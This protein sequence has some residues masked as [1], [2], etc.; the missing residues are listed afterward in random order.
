MKSKKI[1]K[2]VSLLAAAACAVCVTA[3]LPR[4]TALAERAKT[5]VLA[6]DFNAQSLNASVWETTDEA[7]AGVRDYGGAL[8]M[9][10]SDYTHA[11]N[12]MGYHTTA[13]G[14]DGM[15]QDYSLELILTRECLPGN[16]AAIYL[17][18]ESADKGGNE[19]DEGSNGSRGYMLVIND[20]S[21]KL[22]TNST[23]KSTDDVIDP[24]LTADGTRYA[25]KIVTH[26]G[27]QGTDTLDLY[28]VKAPDDPEQPIDYGQMKGSIGVSGSISHIDLRGLFGFGALMGPNDKATFSKVK[29]TEGE[30]TWSPKDDFKTPDIDYIYGSQ[31]ADYSK[32]F[33]NWNSYKDQHVDM[34][35]N[36]PVGKLHVANGGEVVSKQE[37]TLD[38]SLIS[39]LDVSFKLK[40]ANAGDGCVV[41]LGKSGSA[42]LNAVF[43]QTD[44]GLALCL[45]ES[46]VA[47][48]NVTG[49]HSYRLLVRNTGSID[50][51]MDGELAGT[52]V[53][54]AVTD[55]KIGFKAAGSA[56]FEVD[57]LSVLTYSHRDSDEADISID[58][59]EKNSRGFTYLDPD[60]WY[61]AGNALVTRYDEISFVNAE[62]NSVFSS[63]KAYADYIFKFDLFDI[64]Q[65]ENGCS[66]IGISF[67]KPAYEGDWQTAPTIMFA[68]R[69]DGFGGV[70]MNIEGQSGADITG[71]NVKSD[72][73]VF[74]GMGDNSTHKRLNVVLEVVDRTVKLYFKYD[75][76]PESELSIVRAVIEDVNTYGYVGINCNYGGNF[77][78]GNVSLRN[79][80]A[81]RGFIAGYDN[82]VAQGDRVAGDA[83]L[84]L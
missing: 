80:S 14:E 15:Q 74:T 82:R 13:S 75:D 78:V 63:R 5:S 31:A 26:I 62:P 58:F 6:D 37:V 38:K 59:T 11:V 23:L 69:P 27:G 28:T 77:A 43:R 83:A 40:A 2:I 55:G 81:Q 17:G 21:A 42:S 54:T 72:H 76:E 84:H 4:G 50:V 48:G 53:G 45:G 30:K 49:E 60:E 19:I 22:Y 9:R 12:W 57:D 29:V 1:R 51:Y 39:A 52:L 47:L 33:R 61:T 18:L 64:P 41:E 34:Y 66:W 20:N 35:F 10:N 71:G 8:T 25:I 73:N 65:G 3:V 32:E 46:T 7:N 44:G 56:D 70:N 36:G 24:K 79:L 16:W 67:A 68:P